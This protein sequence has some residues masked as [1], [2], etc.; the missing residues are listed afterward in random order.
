MGE[1]IIRF[2]HDENLAT[3]IVGLIAAAIAMAIIAMV[4]GFDLSAAI[5]S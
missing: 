5:T 1:C 3:S 2:F 4:Q